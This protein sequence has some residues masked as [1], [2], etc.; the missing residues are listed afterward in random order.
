MS[1]SDIRR[2]LTQRLAYLEV[3]IAEGRCSPRVLSFRRHE[4]DALR[5][6]LE[7]LGLLE[8]KRLEAKTQ[9]VRDL[10]LPA[11]HRNIAYRAEQHERHRELA[12]RA[13]RLA[14]DIQR[15]ARVA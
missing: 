11:I 2:A 1:P 7:R 15:V 13:E 12:D 4:R 8:P 5:S 3:Q 10:V 14:V 9:A 6:V